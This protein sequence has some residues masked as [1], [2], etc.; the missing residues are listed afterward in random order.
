MVRCGLIVALI[1]AALDQLSKWVVLLWVMNPPRVIDVTGFFNLVLVW[2]RG[3]SFGLF[4]HKSIWGPILLGALTVGIIIFLF[5]WLRSAQTRLT[6]VA[7]GLVMGGALGNLVDRIAH[8]AVVDF[9]DFHAMGYHWPAFNVADSAITIG[10]GL[11]IFESL[12]ERQEK[13]I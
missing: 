5:F 8:Q 6:A 13:P 3:V 11:I 9:L 2:N 10:V 12:F 4:Q 1:V 7:V